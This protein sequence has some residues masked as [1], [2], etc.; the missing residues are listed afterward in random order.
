M[1]AAVE[2]KIVY[3]KRISMGKLQLD[4]ELELGEYKELYDDDLANLNN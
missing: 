3:L 1:F 2:N 4:P